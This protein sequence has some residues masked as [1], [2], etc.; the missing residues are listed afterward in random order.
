MES[1]GFATYSNVTFLY[2]IGKIACKSTEFL[3]EGLKALNDFLSLWDYY[4][5][6]M[7]EKEYKRRKVKAHYYVGIL[8]Y[9]NQEYESSKEYLSDIMQ[10]LEEFGFKE[11][12]QKA[13]TKLCKIYSKERKIIIEN[14]F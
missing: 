11:M 9:I 13:Q 8:F 7:D 12:F 6:D 2:Y 3:E 10:E 4:R 14:Y 1:E 5:F